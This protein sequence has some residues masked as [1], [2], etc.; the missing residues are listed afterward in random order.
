VQ[1]VAAGIWRAS[2]EVGGKSVAVRRSAAGSV[3][4]S[5]PTM[6]VRQEGRCRSYRYGGPVEGSSWTY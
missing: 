1:V 3:F 2:A 4:M 5:S 6:C